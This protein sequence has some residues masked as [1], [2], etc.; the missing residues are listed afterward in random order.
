M[1]L[2]LRYLSKI[3]SCRGEVTRGRYHRY[4]SSRLHA[5]AVGHLVESGSLVVL[6]FFG[7]EDGREW[8]VRLGWMCCLIGLKSYGPHSPT[9]HI[10]AKRIFFFL[11]F[12]SRLSLVIVAFG[13]DLGRMEMSTQGMCYTF[14]CFSILKEGSIGRYG[15]HG[16]VHVWYWIP[17]GVRWSEKDK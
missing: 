12:A 10:R 6:L 16:I 1:L 3:G 8:I 13:W 2:R 14:L 7:F 17:S 11:L 15:P 4:D 9:V 5:C